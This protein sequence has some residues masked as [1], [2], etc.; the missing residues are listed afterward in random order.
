MSIVYIVYEHGLYADYKQIC[1]FNYSIRYYNY[2]K[3]IYVIFC[4]CTIFIYY[5]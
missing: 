5:I 3:Y 1:F 4:K 2:Y